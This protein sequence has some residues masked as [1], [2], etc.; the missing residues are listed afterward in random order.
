[1]M[2]TWAPSLA[3]ISAAHG[4]AT[5]WCCRLIWQ[6]GLAALVLS[7]AP[8]A[9]GQLPGPPSVPMGDPRLRQ[10]EDP[11][12]QRLPMPGFEPAEKPQPLRVPEQ[13]RP[14]PYEE[15]APGPRV[16]VR[17]IRLSGNTAFS[18]EVLAEVTA[19]YTDRYLST[20]D[21]EAI[22]QALTLYYVERGYINSGAVIPDQKV[23]DGV[24]EIRI[25]EG[26]LTNIAVEG[27]EWLRE[28]YIKKRL[29]RGAGRPLNM[30]SLE[31]ELQILQQGPYIRRING[32]LA[33]GDRPGEAS[34]L[35]N[36]EEGSRYRVTTSTDNDLNPSIGSIRGVLGTTMFSPLG[37][38]DAASVTYAHAE[39]LQDWIGD[40]S[41]PL[42]AW[43][44]TLSLFGRWIDSDVVERPFDDLDIDSRQRTYAVRLSHPVIR[45]VRQ[46][47]NL[48]VGFDRRYSRSSLLGQGFAFS[49]GVPPNGKYDISVLRLIQNWLA[50]RR[51]QVIAARSTFSIGVDAF[52]ATTNDESDLPD[53]EFF[54]WLG[55][56]QVARRLRFLDS[57]LVFRL[58]A[59]L[60]NDP[61]LPIEQFGL[62]GPYS[63][64]GYR[65]NLYVRDKGYTT[66]LEFR[67][68]VIRRATGESALQLVSFVDAGGAWFEKR[69]ELEDENIS[70]VGVGLRLDPHPRVHGELYYG[71][72]FDSVRTNAVDNDIQDDGIHF[73][74][75]AN[76]FD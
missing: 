51:N 20:E 31:E 47:L 48:A 7:V 17:E 36:V 25:V 6:S 50:R 62:G 11:S 14:A 53:G 16:F 21:L 18:T 64:R 37:L 75:R 35:A 2:C 56:F 3:R 10:L 68:P 74:L 30:K 55:Q 40:Y 23:V 9:L 24:V 4:P 42:N 1:M 13:E 41:I 44:T 22:R 67:L 73:L 27:N 69:P 71:Y 66:S 59:Q 54:A 58:D 63:V 33:P 49:P 43:D 70:A 52:G 72:A 57:E 61:L 38:G 65:K 34:L 26:E 15:T 60:T 8:V 76:L 5:L 32:D 28:R 39:G 29:E 19:P 46:Q 45:T 12:D